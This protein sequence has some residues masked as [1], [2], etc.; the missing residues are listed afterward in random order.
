M[1]L[2]EA[3]VG[4]D[5]VIKDVCTEDEELR[6]FLLSLGCYSGETITLVSVQ[7]S[8]YVLAIKDARY[9]IDRDIAKMIEI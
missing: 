4:E 7:K 3:K 5:V 9:N 6:G 8:G 1:N 2:T